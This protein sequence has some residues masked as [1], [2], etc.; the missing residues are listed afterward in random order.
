MVCQAAE[1]MCHS[2]S[3][4]DVESQSEMLGESERH[5]QRESEGGHELGIGMM[6][7]GIGFGAAMLVFFLEVF[8]TGGSC[9]RSFHSC[10]YASFM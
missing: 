5:C 1:E 2:E 4:G 10:N 8:G 3:H 9:L 6:N 7:K